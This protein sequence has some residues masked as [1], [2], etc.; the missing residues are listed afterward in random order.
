MVLLMRAVLVKKETTLALVFIQVRLIR[1]RESIN[2]KD[3]NLKSSL[4]FHI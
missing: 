1:K 3:D 2:E 4:T